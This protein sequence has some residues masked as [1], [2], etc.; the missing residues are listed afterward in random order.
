MLYGK[1]N[2]VREAAVLANILTLKSCKVCCVKFKCHL[3]VLFHAYY[4]TVLY[5]S[6]WICKNCP[7]SHKNWNPIYCWTLNLH[8]C[9]TQ[10]HQ[11]HGYRWP[12][13][14]SQTAFADPVKSRRCITGSVEP[15]N[16][17]N[18][19]VIGVRLLPM[20]I[21]TYHVDWACLCHLLKTQ[22]CCL[23]PNRRCNP[24]PATT[25]SHYPSHPHSPAYP[26]YVP[27]MILQSLWNKLFKTQ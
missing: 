22:H 6:D 7:K 3:L 10:K 25:H 15:V 1:L 18:K 17:I 11:T 9:T 2:T 13:L 19:D 23:C 12:S 16:G 4:A 8:S 26:Y 14:L 24:L 27:F 21:S 20:T 5:I